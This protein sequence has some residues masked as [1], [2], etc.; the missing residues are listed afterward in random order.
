M[1][2]AWELQA[3]GGLPA[4]AQ[5]VCRQSVCVAMLRRRSARAHSC[6]LAVRRGWC[7]LLCMCVEC[8]DVLVPRVTLHRMQ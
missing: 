7:L 1:R 4:H 5:R 3:V 6:I 2:L 8:I